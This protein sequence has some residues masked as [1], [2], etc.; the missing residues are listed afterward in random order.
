MSDLSVKISALIYII[1]VC[2][3]IFFIFYTQYKYPKQ[4]GGN[5]DRYDKLMAMSVPFILLP[6]VVIAIIFITLKFVHF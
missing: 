1:F 3:L 4:K 5:S 6:L 2:I